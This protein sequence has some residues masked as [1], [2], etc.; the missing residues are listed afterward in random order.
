MIGWVCDPDEPPPIK[1]ISEARIEEGR[2]AFNDM[3]PGEYSLLFW[4]DINL[5]GRPEQAVDIIAPT[6]LVRIE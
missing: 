3:R 2:F 6:R 5:N 4:V 1:P